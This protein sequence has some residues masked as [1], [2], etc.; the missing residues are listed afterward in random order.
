ML[1]IFTNFLLIKKN[2]MQLLKI[3]LHLQLL[4]NVG[5]IPQVV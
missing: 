1:D 3:P 5:F 4:E 2:L